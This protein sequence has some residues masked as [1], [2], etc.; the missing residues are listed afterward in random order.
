MERKSKTTITEVIGET[1]I[2]VGK[3]K[4]TCD[5]SDTSIPKPLPQQG[6]FA[7]LLVGK[8]RSG[9]T[10]LLL[11]LLWRMT[12]LSYY[13]KTKSMKKQLYKT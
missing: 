2:N 8:P 3:F 5:D 12:L 1:P 13:P 9:K 4:F 7:M 6:G 10:N 11:N